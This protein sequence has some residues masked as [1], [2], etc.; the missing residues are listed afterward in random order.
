MKILKINKENKVRVI[1]KLK[2]EITKGAVVVF[3]TDTVYGLL[4]S[5]ESKVA[6]EK[7]FKIKKR[8][9]K[10]PLPVFV[11]D[12]KNAKKLAIIDKQKEK[13]L[14]K[15]WPGKVTVVLKAKKYKFPKGILNKEGKIGLRIPKYGL[16]NLLIGKL[17]FPLAETSA[18]I[19]GKKSN[20]GI[21]EIL[22]DFKNQKIK[23]DFILDKGN[24]KKS[25][26][27]TVIDLTT[28]EILREGQF[29]K[30][31]LIDLLKK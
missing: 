24:L 1:E 27:S 29:P 31:E 13:F 15:V 21:A 20:V 11:K 5:L 4:A 9:G 19:S 3:P 10:K 28:S 8:D 26:S 17:K 14:R 18:N 22:E 7:I 30:R 16:L 23:P 2:I 6:V 12:I 25:L